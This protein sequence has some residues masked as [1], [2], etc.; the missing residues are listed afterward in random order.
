VIG[1][2]EFIFDPH[3]HIAWFGLVEVG[4]ARAIR[5]AEGGSNEGAVFFTRM[6]AF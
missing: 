5:T 1:E 3:W 2:G 6:V 4:R